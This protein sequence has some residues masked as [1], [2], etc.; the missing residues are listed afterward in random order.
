VR[1]SEMA[2]VLADGGSD[3]L[4]LFNRFYQ[5]EIDT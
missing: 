3:A 5:P 1:I 2:R 4:V